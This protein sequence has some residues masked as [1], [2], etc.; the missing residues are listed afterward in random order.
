MIIT[1]LQFFL[2]LSI[3]VVLH[4]LGHFVTAKWFKTKVEKFY[5]FFNPGFALFKKQ[6]GET[7]YGIGWLPLGGYVKIAGMIDESF[8]T[9]QMAKEPQPWEF[10]SKPA[11]QR[12]IIMVG[13]V[14][15][16]AV[17]GVFLFTMILQIWGTEYILN[18]ELPEGIAVSETAYKMGL[19]DGDKI[20]KVGDFQLEK[21]SSGAVTKELVINQANTITV[22]REG[23]QQTLTVDPE[24]VQE[25]TKH[26]NR[27][28]QVVAVRRPYVFSLLTEDG[29]A[30]KAGLMEGDRIM[31][32]NGTPTPYAHQYIKEM[33]QFH[34]PKQ[35]FLKKL[36]AKLMGKEQPKKVIPKTVDIQISRDNRQ[37]DFTVPM[38]NGK[39]GV[40]PQALDKL[41]PVYN[42][43]YNL[44]EA[45]VGGWDKSV[46]FISDQIKAFGQM[47]SGK[48]KAKD[49]LGSFITIG[50]M[51]GTNWDWQRFW[52]MTAT[53]SL[54]LGFL[55]LL[56]IPALD[57]GYVMFLIFETLTGKKVPDRVMEIA[58][59]IGFLLLMVLMIYAFGLDISR[60]L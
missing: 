50:S 1:I 39:I 54:L 30:K 33:A 25:L 18:D 34:V 40:Y 46:N 14:F 10:R 42:Q 58:T 59:F 60:T 45:M 11:W 3:L 2:S 26:E 31:A 49:S 20:L 22:Q 36:V 48:I 38:S 27:N 6:I 15:V 37:L 51:F 5:L 57:G 24:L 56:P 44:S 9:E 16:N 28:V 53:L 12:L 8:D 17:L 47:F 29:G 52:S 7:E 32:V 55:N 23:S 41:L 21:F 4:E 35:S 13:G 19:R 43:E